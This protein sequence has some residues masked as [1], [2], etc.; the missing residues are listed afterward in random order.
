MAE[1]GD[2]KSY[3]NDDVAMLAEFN[4]AVITAD[5]REV[6]RQVFAEDFCIQDFVYPKVRDAE[7]F[8]IRQ[9]QRA[10]IISNIDGSYIHRSALIA[11][12]LG[13]GN[14]PIK[15]LSCLEL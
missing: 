2:S 9:G 6:L 13:W 14:I 8:Y 11:K 4:E 3:G 7:N 5:D 15:S 12:C 10:Y 1:L